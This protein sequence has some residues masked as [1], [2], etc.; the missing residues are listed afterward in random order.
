M[1]KSFHI[2]VPDTVLQ[3]LHNRLERTR[4]PPDSYD[5]SWEDGTNPAYLRQLVRY[6]R[7]QYDW[8]RQEKLLNQLNHLRGQV[9]GTDLHLIH[10]R[11]VGP[12]PLPILLT[13][14][15]PD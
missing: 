7:E 1:L 3:D 12:S 15:Y 5:D 14:G 4:F 10:Q 9:D 6:W 11:G 13:H 2:D 8:R